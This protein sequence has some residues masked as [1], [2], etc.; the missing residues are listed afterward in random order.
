MN[1]MPNSPNKLHAL[2]S[3]IPSSSSSSHQ[4]IKHKKTPNIQ[5]MPPKSAHKTNS[6]ITQN[7]TSAATLPKFPASLTAAPVNCGGAVPFVVGLPMADGLVIMVDEAAVPITTNTNTKLARLAQLLLPNYRPQN[8]RK[9]V[10]Y[11]PT[12]AVVVPVTVAVGDADADEDAEPEV[13]AEE[14]ECSTLNTELR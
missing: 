4:V 10:Q 13:E 1:T 11:S 12:T 3:L 7:P 14:E 5:P 2:F 6:P 8:L 9:S